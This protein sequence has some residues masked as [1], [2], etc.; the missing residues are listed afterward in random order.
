MAS[1]K[2]MIEDA[3]VSCYDSHS[4]DYDIYQSTVVPHYQD[5]LEIVSET[6]KRYI[7]PNSNIIDLGCGTGNAS[8]AIL[9]KLPARIFLIDGSSHMLDIALGKINQAHANIIAGYRTS[10]SER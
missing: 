1:F 7:K 4:N 2:V 6:C 9:G 8:L 10:R 3:T 5:M